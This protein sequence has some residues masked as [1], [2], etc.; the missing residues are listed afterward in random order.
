MARR[1]AVS[2]TKGSLHVT[3]HDRQR[4]P[5]T[6]GRAD[7]AGR[8]CRS[9]RQ[10]A[11]ALGPP[12]GAARCSAAVRP[13]ARARALAR[14]ALRAAAG[15]PRASRS[16]AVHHGWG[17]V[18]GER[19]HLGRRATHVPAPLLRPVRGVGSREAARAGACLP[20]GRAALRKAQAAHGHASA[21]GGRPR[22]PRDGAA[23]R[24]PHAPPLW[25]RACRDCAREYPP[26]WGGVPGI[27][28][29]HAIDGAG[30]GCLRGLG[31][32]CGSNQAG[33]FCAALGRCLQGVPPI[34]TRVKD[35][36]AA[37][38]KAPMPGTPHEAGESAPAVLGGA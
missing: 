11:R 10:L 13:P 17:P 1:G 26:W 15:G 27:R 29:G 12:G 35:A 16:A 23:A 14:R 33:G 32:L 7:P 37:G 28:G 19:G 9:R 2:E 4:L 22:V 38:V 24:E 30:A 31:H 18:V 25:L 34:Y 8:L 36:S 20:Q 3:G 6:C 21:C 5:H